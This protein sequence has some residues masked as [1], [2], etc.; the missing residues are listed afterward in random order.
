MKD[1]ITYCKDYII[2]NLPEH[3]GRLVYT[4]DLGYDLTEGP[5]ADGTLTYSS[6]EAKEYLR[7]W[8]DEADDYY[9]YERN[10]FGTGGHNPF[11]DPEAYMVC[12]VIEG[13]NTLIYQAFYALGIDGGEQV[14]LTGDLI[15]Q[16]TEKVNENDTYRL[17]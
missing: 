11:A 13:V 2:D 15:E 8:W 5:N 6:Y 14:E 7:E 4:C 16:I 1:F 3:E 9:E 12:M 17:F 10:N